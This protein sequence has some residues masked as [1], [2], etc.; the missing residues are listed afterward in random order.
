MTAVKECQ[1]P[2]A[3][4]RENPIERAL[5]LARHRACL[6]AHPEQHPRH[7][8]GRDQ[9]RRA[10]EDLLP[11]CLQ[12]AE[13]RE[14]HESQ[15]RAGRHGGRHAQPDPAE[16]SS[17]AGPGQ[18]GADDAD[19]QGGFHALAQAGQQAAREGADIEH[20]GSL[21][22]THGTHPQRRGVAASASG[23]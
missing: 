21:M 12:L 13:S 18:V 15:R 6:A 20:A 1:A 19:D 10:L 14:D 2:G 4:R 16:V 22:G 3:P 17:V 9:H 7:D 11:G 5:E 23:M 8:G